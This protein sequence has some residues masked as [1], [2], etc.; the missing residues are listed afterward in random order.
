MWRSAYISR[1]VIKISWAFPIWRCRFTRKGI[2][3]KKMRLSHNRLI[4]ITKIPT[5]GKTVFILRRGPG[6]WAGGTCAFGCSSLW[7]NRAGFSLLLIG[8]LE[9]N[10]QWRIG[11]QQLKLEVLLYWP[12]WVML[13]GNRK[14]NINYDSQRNVEENMSNFVVGIVPVDCLTPDRIRTA[15]SIRN[16]RCKS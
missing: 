13:S 16:R 9:A 1:F 8:F 11:D 10:L 7:N 3:I 2:P 6:A 5:P 4:F 14:A 12:F 15:V